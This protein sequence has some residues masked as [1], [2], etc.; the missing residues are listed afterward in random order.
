MP[1][2][3]PTDATWAPEAL[4]PGT[5]Y[6]VVRALGEGGMGQVYEVEHVTARTR[7]AF[8][9][10]S[11][12]Y[13]GRH[14]LARRLLDEAR[15]LKRFDGHDHIVK[16]TDSG[17]T[18]DGHV[19]YVME[20]LYGHSLRDELRGRQSLPDGPRP[21][22]LVWAFQVLLPVLAALDAT[23]AHGV[24]HR[25]IKPDN[26]FLTNEGVVKLLDFG[27]AKWA[28]DNA[29]PGGPDA[30]P[31]DFMGTTLYAAPECLERRPFDGRA[32]LYS[33]G[34]VLWE[35]LA[36][37]HPF[38]GLNA[39]QVVAHATKQGVP[40][41][42]SNLL[43]LSLPESVHEL[44]RRATALDPGHRYAT[45]REFADAI[46]RVLEAIAP[47][48]LPHLVPPPRKREP[49]LSAFLRST[50]R[51]SHPSYSGVSEPALSF[52]SA[53]PP[54]ASS[55]PAPPPR[56]SSAS[57]PL[58]RAS[59]APALPPR[60]SSAPALPSHVSS[61][62]APPPR[63]S[64]APV[65]PARVSSAPTPPP[66][67]VSIAVPPEALAAAQGAAGVTAL[68]QAGALPSSPGGRRVTL[69]LAL[70]VVLAMPTIGLGALSLVKGRGE[71]LGQGA[72]ASPAPLPP[73]SVEPPTDAAAR[74]AVA[75]EPAAPAD[76]PAPADQAS[77]PADKASAPA[78]KAP[79]ADQASAP[80]DKAPA[81]A[82]KAAAPTDQASVPT[83]KAP[84][85]PAPAV[86]AP[87]PAD[88]SAQNKPGQPAVKRPAPPSPASP[89]TR[90]RRYPKIEL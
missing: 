64:S 33:L 29:E 87:A 88:D 44:V 35:L 20:R 74:P 59:S 38:T 67:S 27:V 32:D 19:Y 48:A 81:S 15:A 47:E 18:G 50:G 6:R 69:F 30:S 90:P 79:A 52:A 16:V 2:P 78:D 57:A 82:G 70:F 55:A 63:M 53:P 49:S 72:T 65:L 39:A 77:A 83:A 14:D 76:K 43:G 23:H 71:A 56:A 10:L 8:K 37:M 45:A 66:S 31:G 46:L 51:Q 12:Q 9:A 80:A 34:V 13:S 26:I 58:P 17:T 41:L 25:D 42:K 3:S 68:G 36:G 60:A 24:I 75:A 85:A 11:R 1:K 73:P 22:F 62:S 89:S 40:P 7:H 5:S 61:V 4:I 28:S 84:V 21:D 86:K 54:R